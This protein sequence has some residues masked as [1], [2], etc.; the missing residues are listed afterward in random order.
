MGYVLWGAG[1]AG[2]GCVCDAGCKAETD[3]DGWGSWWV[4]GQGFGLDGA[5]GA[6][7]GGGYVVVGEGWEGCGEGGGACC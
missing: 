4:G 2:V 3:V 1:G 5:W 7:R 6:G